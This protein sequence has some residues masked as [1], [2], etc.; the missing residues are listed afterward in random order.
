MLRRSL[1]CMEQRDVLPHFQ[2]KE[3]ASTHPPQYRQ[4][5]C[6]S[7]QLLQQYQ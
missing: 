5:S 2:T 7:L 6:G 3:K 1:L 4:W